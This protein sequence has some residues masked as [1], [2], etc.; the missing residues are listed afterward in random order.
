MS[1][2]F[3]ALSRK[4]E[5]PQLTPDLCKSVWRN[6]EDSGEIDRALADMVVR[7]WGDA[8]IVDQAGLSEWVEVIEDEHSGFTEKFI[9]GALLSLE[10]RRE[11]VLVAEDY[12]ESEV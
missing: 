11:K 3:A 5:R 9:A 12:F 8:A 6:T 4:S 1:R 2:L 7:N 10:K